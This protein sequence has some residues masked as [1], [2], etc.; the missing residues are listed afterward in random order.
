M[1]DAQRL[2]ALDALAHGHHVAEADAV[3]DAVAGAAPAAAQ[4]DDGSPMSRVALRC[5]QPALA[6]PAPARCTGAA[7]R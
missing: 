6:A 4:F 5:T 1:H 3:V 2:A 7:G